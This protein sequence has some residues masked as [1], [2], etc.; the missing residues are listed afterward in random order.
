MFQRKYK[1][2]GLNSFFDFIF[3][4]RRSFT[5]QSGSAQA[6]PAFPLRPVNI[7]ID[8]F[9]FLDSGDVLHLVQIPC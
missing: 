1:P 4:L 8:A 6:S 9:F 5:N 7:A 2:S 3:V